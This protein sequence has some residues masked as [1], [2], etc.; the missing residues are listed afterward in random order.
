MRLQVEIRPVCDAFKLVPLPLFVFAVGEETILKVYAALRIMGQFL[1]RLP[2][3]SQVFRSQAELDVPVVSVFDPS[4]VT[5]GELAGAGDVALA[6]LQSGGTAGTL[7]IAV[8]GVNRDGPRVLALLTPEE[9]TAPPER[10]GETGDEAGAAAGAP[11][12]GGGGSDRE[13]GRR[14]HGGHR[15]GGRDRHRGPR[16]EQ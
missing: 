16:R 8:V 7:A 2:V 4:L 15:G 14:D 10:T 3:L 13:G 1:A 5:Y 9:G 6:P 11:R 12:E